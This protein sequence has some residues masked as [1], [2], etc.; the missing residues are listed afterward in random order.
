MNALHIESERKAV[1][2]LGDIALDSIERIVVTRWGKEG[3]PSPIITLKDSQE[4]SY[5]LYIHRDVEV[6]EFY[7]DWN[8]YRSLASNTAYVSFTVKVKT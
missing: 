1:K 4:I 2:R 5:F 3:K 7:S 8:E 6:S